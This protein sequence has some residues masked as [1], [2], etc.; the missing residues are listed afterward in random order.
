V[1]AH[2]NC[3]RHPPRISISAAA[4]ADQA[5]NIGILRIAFANTLLLS[6]QGISLVIP[7]A[8]SDFPP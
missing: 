5:E 7:G 1:F 2:L 6:S 8:F 3:G 4:L